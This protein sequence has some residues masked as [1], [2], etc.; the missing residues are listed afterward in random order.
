MLVSGADNNFGFKPQSV[1]TSQPP[2]LAMPQRPI[3][4]SSTRGRILEHRTVCLGNGVQPN[5]SRQINS[6]APATDHRQIH[7]GGEPF[8]GLEPDGVFSQWQNLTREQA[9]RRQSMA[10][11]CRVCN[12]PFAYASGLK[13][14]LR[15]HS[16]ERP[17]QCRYCTRKFKQPSHLKTHLAQHS[18]QKPFACKRCNAR[19]A[20]NSLLKVHQDTHGKKEG[21]PCP[22]CGKMHRF[23]ST[24]AAHLRTHNGKKELTCPTCYRRFIRPNALAAHLMTHT[25]QDQTS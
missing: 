10:F 23:P 2:L 19:F 1:G 3:G 9:L 6:T 11:S 25:N 16:G 17:Y 20:S 22:K 7:A 21:L 24:L 5:D 8:S 13:V 15:V 4:D 12:K 14:H 18:E